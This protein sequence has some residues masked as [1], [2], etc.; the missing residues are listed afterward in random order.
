MHKVGVPCIG[1]LLWNYTKVFGQVLGVTFCCATCKGHD[2][3]PIPFHGETI[4]H[5]SLLE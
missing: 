5:L 4:R 3:F 1:V 2:I